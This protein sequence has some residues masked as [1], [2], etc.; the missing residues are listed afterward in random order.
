MPHF[1]AQNFSDQNPP[2][3]NLFDPNLSW[4]AFPFE[5]DGYDF[6]FEAK[7]LKNPKE[8][9]I[10]VRYGDM[11]FFI[12]KIQRENEILFKGEKNTKP[13]PIGILKGALRVLAKKTHLLSHNLNNDSMRQVVRS[14]FL[15]KPSEIPARKLEGFCIEIGFGSG[16][17]LLRMAQKNPD[18]TFIG[19][20]IHTPS[21]EQVLR[22]IELLG[23]E[24]IVIACV[25]ARVLLEILPSNQCEAIYVHFPVPWNK[26]P[27]RRV[28]SARLLSEALRVL[29]QN[30]AIELRTDDAVYFKDSF[31]I[32]ME[33]KNAKLEIAKNLSGEVVS[34]YEARWQRQ[35]KDI[36]DLRI[37]SLNEDEAKKIE[38]DFKIDFVI[39]KHP[40][41]FKN[42][43]KIVREDYFLHICDVFVC[44]ALV[45]FSVSFGDFNWAI[46]KMI[47]FDKEN[48]TASYVGDIPLATPA[49]IKA[50]QELLTLLAE[51]R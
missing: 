13:H 34:K 5:A 33:M 44:D 2:D 37:F 10:G 43:P 4:Q 16:R 22:Q 41:A 47:V 11:L 1:F 49:N 50:H 35:H 31:H 30:K 23:I 39:F 28:I 20:E 17:H 18:K 15:L 36:F 25:D 9:L 45:I 38:Y 29:K 26:K 46:N 42:I 7:S 6:L 8:S 12:R 21:I 14:R 24:N 48:Q 19:V 3:Q 32:V 27:H 51:E 40:E